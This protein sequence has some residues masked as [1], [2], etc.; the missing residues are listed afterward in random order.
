LN[1]SQRNRFLQ[2]ENKKIEKLKI[3]PKSLIILTVIKQCHKNYLVRCGF[4]FSDQ[5]LSHYGSYMNDIVPNFNLL[6]TNELPVLVRPFDL[7]D[8]LDIK[9]PTLIKYGSVKE[10]ITPSESIYKKFAIKKKTGEKRYIIAPVDGLK[11]IQKKIYRFILLQVRASR[12]ATGFI[13]TKSNITNAKNHYGFKVVYILDLKNFFPTIKFSDVFKMYNLKF[14]YSRAIS[15]LLTKLTTHLPRRHSNGMLKLLHNSESFLPQGSPSSPY[16]SNLIFSEADYAL[17]KLSRKYNFEYS[18]Y[19]DDITFSSKTRKIVP[20]KFRA[21]VT[22][23]IKESGF[24][25]NYQKELISRTRQKITGIIAHETH[26]TLPRQWVKRLRAALHELRYIDCEKEVLEVLLNK[27]KN[28]QGRINYAMGVNRGK[29]YHFYLEFQE[30]RLLKFKYL[31][32]DK[33]IK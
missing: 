27:L 33:K 14:G 23:I 16:I 25:I 5:Y 28:V 19:A 21:S 20:T 6:N 9:F 24:Y 1:Y 17:Y 12:F 7:A 3:Y 10:E 30:L 15:F 18:R 8:Y 31:F 32:K 22:K 13:P 29:Y 4:H 2:I 11:E 26:L